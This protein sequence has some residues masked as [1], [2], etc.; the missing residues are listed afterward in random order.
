MKIDALM[1]F[2]VLLPEVVLH[3][4]EV[5][6]L[7]F[8]IEVERIIDFLLE[9]EDAE[10]HEATTAEHYVDLALCVVE[11]GTETAL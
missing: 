7:Y 11:R 5:G 10:S 9:I 3:I 6:Q 4:A 1:I 8:F 2:A